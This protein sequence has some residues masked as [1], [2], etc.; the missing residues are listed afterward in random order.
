MSE[1]IKSNVDDVVRISSREVAEMMEV[2]HDNLLFK[3]EKHTEIFNKVNDLKNKVVNL[4][5]EGTYKD[6]KGEIRK[7]YKVTKKGC[8]FLAHKTTGEKGDLFTIKY[9]EKFEQMEQQLLNP[10]AGLSKELQAIFMLDKKQQEIEASVKKVEIELEDLRDN[11]PLFNSE[12]DELSKCIKRV[13]TQNLGGY[14]TNAY[15]DKSLRSRIYSDIHHVIKREFGIN[16]YK[17]IKHCQLEKA[18]G[19]VLEYQ[20]PFCLEEEVISLN[21]QLSMNV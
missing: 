5:I 1:I 16:S 2:R 9:M 8:E 19:I 21:G 7:D 12:C 14:K 11:S 13:A 18:I 6:A 15:N 4:W 20:L 10:Y 17:S 3:I